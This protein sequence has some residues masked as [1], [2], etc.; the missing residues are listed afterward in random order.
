M[1]ITTLT[2]IPQSFE[3]TITGSPLVLLFGNIPFVFSSIPVPARTFSRRPLTRLAINMPI[4]ITIAAASMRGRY[5]NTFPS[6]S[7]AGSDIE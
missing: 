3:T 6:I 1:F 4:M 2:I 7:D 5:V